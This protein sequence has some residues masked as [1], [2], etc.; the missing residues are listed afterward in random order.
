MKSYIK[1]M[2]LVMLLITATAAKAQTI[3]QANRADWFK[4]AKFGMFIHWGLYSVLGGTYNG[5]TLPDKSFKNGESW[6]AEWIQQRL[7]VPEKEYRALVKQFNHVNFDADAWI[8][9]AKNAGMKY[10]VITSKHHDGFALWDSKVSTYDI[11]STPYKKDILGELAKACKKYG[12]KYGFYY[13]HCEDWEHPGGATPHWT[14]Q[15][16]DAQFEKYWREKCLPQVTELIQRYSP[17]LFWFD[18]WGDEQEKIFISDKRRDE[19]IALIRKQSPKTLINGRISWLNPGND[20]DF[21]EMMDNDYP[22]ELQHRPWQTPAT[23]VH[24]WGWHAK[25][26]NWKTAAEMIGYLVNN[27]SK[28]GNYLLNIGPKPDGTFPP[29][30]I[31]RLREM[32]A[33]MVTNS[34]AVYGAKPLVLKVPKEICLTQ[35][36]I[37]GKQIIYASIINPLAGNKLSLPLDF[38]KIASCSMFDTQMPLKYE[39]AAS[40]VT[41]SLPENIAAM[42]DEVQVIQIEMK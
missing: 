26:Y 22:S 37:N 6:Y 15:K 41:I 38:S 1:N 34:D 24:S 33:W 23:M 20:I 5:H 25:D 18:T 19:L 42:R 27:V 8:K 10:F 11:A 40:D 4:E 31:R 39:G 14:P 3:T 9:E 16:T 12:L 29:M 7:E 36:T 2:A 35:K 28:G 32:G 21:L 30:A 13:S 17:D